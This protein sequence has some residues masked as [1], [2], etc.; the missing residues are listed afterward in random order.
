MSDQIRMAVGWKV[1]T[2]Q[3]AVTYRVTNGGAAPVYVIDGCFHAGP[4][5]VMA[6]SDRLMVGFRPL[7]TAVLGSRLTPLNPAVH[8][9]FPPATFA[10]RLAAGA[11][12]ES[13]LTA[14]LPL[15]PDGMTTESAS[16]AAINGGKR[17]VRPFAG[18]PPQLADRPV[19]C[20][21][22]VFEL[23]VIP[24]DESLHPLPTR[25][26]DRG[27]FRLEKAAWSLQRIV[28]SEPRPVEFPMRVPAT[29]A[30]TVRDERFK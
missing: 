21:A 14:P 24:H 9:T 8:S 27:V 28:N 1:G 3:V 19:V 7:G 2:D 15:V 26:A 25:L 30:E 17:I 5:G 6:W 12:H 4:G 11:T 23:G 29:V 22:V 13:T 10:V 16:P 18:G 20:R